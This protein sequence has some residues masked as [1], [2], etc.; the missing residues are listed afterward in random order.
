LDEGRDLHELHTLI[1][2]RPFFVS[3]GSE[4]TPERWPALNHAIAVNRMLG[5]ENRVGMSNRPAHP[6]TEESSMQIYA[7]FQHFLQSR[8]RIR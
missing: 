6:P 2:P 4:D 8:E 7:F 1:C 3:G 5:F